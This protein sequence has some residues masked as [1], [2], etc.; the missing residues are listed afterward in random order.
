MRNTTF[1]RH[2]FKTALAV[3]ALLA[4]Q[5]L[6]VGAG[7]TTASPV[8]PIAA[9]DLRND[10]G[11]ELRILESFCDDLA[12]Y[13]KQCGQ[14]RRRQ[15]IRQVDLD[16]LQPKSADLRGRVS[17][18]QNAFREIIRK[19]KAANAWDDLDTKLSAHN[20]DPK[21]RT[22]FQGGSFKQELEEVA[23]GLSSQAN[24][25][26]TPL[27]N[28]RRRLTAQTFSSDRIAAVVRVAYSSP[29]PVAFGPGLA[30]RVQRAR[31][32]LIKFLGGTPT[33][34]TWDQISCNCN[35]MSAGV[36]TGTPC[37]EVLGD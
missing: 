28:L 15:S 18:V 17:G 36:G 29:T 34:E 7:A 1:H 27:E 26:N 4:L 21:F 22:L 6:W 33:N 13:N 23:A 19:L 37:S 24:E 8:V 12:A 3:A 5:S 35:G 31:L 9:P 32:K 30:C 10:L 16:P 2:S 11:S 25:I 20:N 14:L